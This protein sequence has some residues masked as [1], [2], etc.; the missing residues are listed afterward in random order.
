MVPRSPGADPEIIMYYEV[1]NKLYIASGGT[2]YLQAVSMEGANAA[3]AEFTN[4]VSGG[5]VTVFIEPGNDLE[6]WSSAAGS[7][8][9]VGAIYGTAKATAVASRFVRLRIE[10]A[11][12]AA[13]LGAGVYTSQQ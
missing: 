1:A 3:L 6:N 11:A 13:I 5:T 12:A 2:A 7:G 10:A 8:S 4:F 9:V